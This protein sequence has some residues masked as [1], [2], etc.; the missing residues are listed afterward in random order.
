MG[1]RAG[2]RSVVWQLRPLAVALLLE[3]LAGCRAQENVVNTGEQCQALTGQYVSTA[4][5]VATD[6]SG[7]DKA[8][9]RTVDRISFDDQGAMISPA[10]PIIVCT[11]RQ[12]NCAISIACDAL[13]I[14]AEF[15]GQIGE[16]AST[17]VGQ[18]TV[19]HMYE[20]CRSIVY[21]VNV[22]RRTP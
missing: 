2:F 6:G 21:D 9:Q 12:D 13:G 18:A 3:P 5:I 17:V 15:D 7:C 19:K 11:T 16:D 8:K 10:D 22:V 20:G 4:T 14:R 1:V